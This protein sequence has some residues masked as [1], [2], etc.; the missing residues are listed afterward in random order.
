MRT[1]VASSDWCASRNVVSVT[2][3][4]GDSRSQR[5]KPSGPASTS[6]CFE[7]HGRLRVLREL[8]QL[9]RRVGRLRALAVRLVDRLVGEVGQ[10]PRAAVGGVPRGE[11]VRPLLDERR[12][13]APGAEVR[14]VEHGL[15]ERDVRGHAADPELGDGAARAADGGLEVAPA[16]GEL[17][18]QRVE[19]GADL[20][21]GEG[22]AAVEPDAG[23]A[24]RAVGGDHPGVRA[25]A[26]GRVFGGDAALQRG[27]AQVDLVLRQAQ[28]V[29][30][31]TG[32]DPQLRLHEVDVGD[33]F[34][35]RVLDLD[36]RVHLDEHVVAL[37]VEQELDG[38]G[39]AVADLLREL[40]RVGADPVAQLGVEVRRRGQLDDLLVTP[41]HRAVALVE[42]DDV[43]HG[44]GEDLHLN[45]PRLHDGLLEE[46]RRVAEG[47]LRLARR[48]LDGLAQL[49]GLQDAA[50]TAPA[51]TG[52]GL[53]EHREAQLVGRRDQRVDVAG[54]LG[55]AEHRY[56]RPR[57]RP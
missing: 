42:V 7:P 28:V 46:H 32:G 47:G 23:A 2:P 29:E 4:C 10:Q 17:H 49:S 40:D 27:A 24:R 31:L 14:V 52:D 1:R 20:G 53:D 45:V 26:V 15:Q 19:V 39:V 34:G 38:A 51:T 8:R 54:G 56:S 48:G 3:M 16:A 18:Q 36:A 13:D 33:L 37:L 22:G 12:R 50:H 55:R 44:V 41:L 21:A 6:F 43:A 11:Q 9:E 35:D 30:G 25:E 57:A 5:A